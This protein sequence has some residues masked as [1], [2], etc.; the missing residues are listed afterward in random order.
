M[1]TERPAPLTQAQIAARKKLAKQP[2]Q[3]V[4]IYNKSRMQTVHIQL[5]PPAGVPFVVG[6]QTVPLLPMGSSKFPK[7]R[8]MS[9][10]ITN[11]TKSGLLRVLEQ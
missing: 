10:Q 6:E 2:E 11:L 8:L 3:Y 4:T 1:G 5:R 7:S 9:D